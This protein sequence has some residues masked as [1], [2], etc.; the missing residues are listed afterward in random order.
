MVAIITCH[1]VL[2]CSTISDESMKPSI[3][4]SH[5]DTRYPEYS[6]KPI[7]IFINKENEFFFSKQIISLPFFMRSSI[8]ELVV[9]LHEISK[10]IAETSHPH[11]IGE[12]LLLPAVK[13]ITSCLYQNKKISWI[14]CP[15]L[16]IHWSVELWIGQ[17]ISK[18]LL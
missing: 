17:K 4:K 16:I 7:D 2:C 3:M 13:I 1:C 10:L 12:T 11:T 8:E 14:Y 6:S 15:H 9:A 5:M 18:K